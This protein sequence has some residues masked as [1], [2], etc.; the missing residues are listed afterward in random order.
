MEFSTKIDSIP[1]PRAPAVPKKGKEAAP[2]VVLKKPEAPDATLRLSSEELRKRISEMTRK[3]SSV[4]ELKMYYDEDADQVV[5][6]ILD[7]STKR[8]LRQIPSADFL[9]FVKR[10]Q[11]YL[12]TMVDRRV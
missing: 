1:E 6:T 12:G 11:Q 5:V 9:N 7:G 4:S 8:V 10:F 2:R 3:L